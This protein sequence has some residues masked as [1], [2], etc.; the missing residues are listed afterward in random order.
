MYSRHVEK[1]DSRL[2]RAAVFMIRAFP[3]V[4]YRSSW[5]KLLRLVKAS[6]ERVAIGVGH[7]FRGLVKSPR[8]L[9][10]RAY[11]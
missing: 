2:R 5:A 10:A 11:V 4:I 7:L 8:S 9:V 6:A 3:S 1:R